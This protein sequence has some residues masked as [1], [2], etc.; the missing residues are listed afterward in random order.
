MSDSFFSLNKT[1]S[2]AT[3]YVGKIHSV[4]IV[5]VHELQFP[6]ESCNRYE[7]YSTLVI[8]TLHVETGKV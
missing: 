7:Q 3:L 5:F 2:R 8:S 4:V 1:L 6:T